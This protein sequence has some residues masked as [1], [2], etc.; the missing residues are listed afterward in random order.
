MIV[1]DAS[2]L[3]ELLLNTRNGKRVAERISSAEVTLN[4]PHLIDLEVTQVIRR[5]VRKGAI[6]VAR[7]KQ[8]VDHLLSL[9]LERYPH[10]ILLPGIW[11]R[12]DRITAYDAAYIVLADLLDAPLLT[13]DTKLAQVSERC[14]IIG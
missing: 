13:L 1:L 9:D 3:I 5:L 12:R 10:D 8:A 2:S 7:G 4:A 11:T 6:G 14:E